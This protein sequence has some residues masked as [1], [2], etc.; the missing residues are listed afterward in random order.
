M[1]NVQVLALALALAPLPLLHVAP[2]RTP[3]ATK[4]GVT[5]ALHCASCLR[6]HSISHIYINPKR[7]FWHT[8]RARESHGGIN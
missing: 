4:R 1:S 6:P 2:E 5:F 7:S 3:S 8:T